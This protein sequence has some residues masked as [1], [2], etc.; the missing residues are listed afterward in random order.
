MVKKHKFL[1]KKKHELCAKGKVYIMNFSDKGNVV[2]MVF[3]E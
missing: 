3:W 1:W 2:R